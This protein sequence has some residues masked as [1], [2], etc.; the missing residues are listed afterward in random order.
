MADTE[1]KVFEFIEAYSKLK[2]ERK[3]I[4]PSLESAVNSAQDL[5]RYSGAD[6]SKRLDDIVKEARNIGIIIDKFDLVA[7]V[8]RQQNAKGMSRDVD[9]MGRAGRRRL[10]HPTM[11]GK[12][13]MRKMRKTRRRY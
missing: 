13:N 12:K 5:T 9:K 4:S 2:Q 11:K 10:G 1:L 7:M 8:G 3:V 6:L